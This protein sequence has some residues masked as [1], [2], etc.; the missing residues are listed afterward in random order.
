MKLRLK[1]LL[2]SL[3]LTLILL[4]FSDI[5]ITSLLPALGLRHF[6]MSIHILIVI[7]LGFYIQTPYISL[8]ILLIQLVH[9]LFT[10]EGW[11]HGTFTGVVLIMLLNYLKD[12]LQFRS[13]LFT[14]LLTFVLQYLWFFIVASLIYFRVGNFE[15]YSQSFFDILPETL[16]VSF[17]SPFFFSVLSKIWKVQLGEGGERV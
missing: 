17:I 3:S 12:L 13:A 15:Y 16:V 9:S 11:A 2:S 1:D 8:L 4:I 6:N 10:V 5:L 7:F 14:F